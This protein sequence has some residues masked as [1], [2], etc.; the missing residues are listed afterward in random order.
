MSDSRQW[1]NIARRGSINVLIPGLLFRPCGGIAIRRSGFR[2]S[3]TGSLKP[4]S[5]SNRRPH[6][7][8]HQPF[9]ILDRATHIDPITRAAE[10]AHFRVAGIPEGPRL[11]VE[12][13]GQVL[14]LASANESASK[15]ISLLVDMVNIVVYTKL[16]RTSIIKNKPTC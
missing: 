3:E 5:N 6:Q 12:D 4:Q 10:F 7:L 2:T 14:Y 9:K 15:Q 1:Y 13:W 11:R 8:T 16:N